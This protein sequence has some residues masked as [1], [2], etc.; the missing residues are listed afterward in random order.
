MAYG[1]L[2]SAFLATAHAHGQVVYV[3]IDPDV[4]VDGST[5]PLDL[6][7]NGTVDF[8]FKQGSYQNSSTPT[9]SQQTAWMQPANVPGAQNGA[10]SYEVGPGAYDFA[11]A[12]PAGAIIA[13]S[14][15][16]QITFEAAQQNGGYATIILENGIVYT[17]S[18]TDLNQGVWGGQDAYLGVFFKAG[19]NKHYGWIGIEVSDFGTSMI[20]K[21]YAYQATPNTGV[22]AGSLGTVGVA[23]RQRV[24]PL[25]L[26]PNPAAGRTTLYF[27]ALQSGKCAVRLVGLSGGAVWQHNFNVSSGP[28]VLALELGELA[29]GTYV[30]E[31]QQEDVVVRQ[32]LQKVR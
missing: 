8:V 29:T 13:P 15:P 2:A 10:I 5:Y 6:D 23:E 28:N 31:L 19:A 21:E 18:G 25:R 4:V 24:G 30:V 26:A 1:A 11:T 3:D 32:R 14:S 17:G 22:V 16:N 12:L 7:I 27:E 9:Y 20:L